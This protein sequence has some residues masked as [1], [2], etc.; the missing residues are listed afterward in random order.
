MRVIFGQKTQFAVGARRGRFD[1]QDRLEKAPGHGLAR[2]REIL[3]RS[4]GLGTIEG[5]RR[6]ADFSHAVFFYAS[7]HGFT[8][9]SPVAAAVEKSAGT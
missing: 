3:H 9:S 1:Q 2:D 7:F 8:V 4:L 6:Y 5:M